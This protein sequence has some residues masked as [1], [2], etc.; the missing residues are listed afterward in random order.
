[1]A[2]N[3][4][5]RRWTWEKGN[6]NV[7]SAVF[8]LRR[9][10][11]V[12]SAQYFYEIRKF[13]HHWNPLR[14]NLRSI[15]V[16]FFG[17]F[18]PTPSADNKPPTMRNGPS[19]TFHTTLQLILVLIHISSKHLPPESQGFFSHIIHHV[20]H[21]YTFSSMETCKRTISVLLF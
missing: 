14:G 20:T 16:D 18:V 15:T 13:T 1:M 6:R 19:H 5:A 10:R 2:L 21:F 11:S 3:Q 17:M 4:R 7:C 9:R 12:M 8:A